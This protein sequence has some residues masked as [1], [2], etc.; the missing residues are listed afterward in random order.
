MA[1]D[2]QR[3]SVSPSHPTPLA[4]GLGIH[5]RSSLGASKA[6]DI[7]LN[8]SSPPQTPPP[9][10]PPPHHAPRPSSATGLSSGTN[11]GG[12]FDEHATLYDPGHGMAYEPSSSTRN[13]FPSSSPYAPSD[14]ESQRTSVTGAIQEKYHDYSAKHG[15][16]CTGSKHSRRCYKTW[17]GLTFVFLALFSTVFSGIFLVLA[18]YN[19]RY[20]STIGRKGR[21]T[22]SD[23]AT[24]T[25]VFAKA[26]ELSFTA[27]VVALIGQVLARRAYGKH[28]SKHPGVTL[29]EL[30]MRNW[31][32]QPGTMFTHWETVRYA[33]LS[34]LGVV[35]LLATVL[36]F[37]YT[38]AA[39]ALVQPQLKDLE[40][41]NRQLQG[42]VRTS[43]SNPE[44]FKRTCVAPLARLPQSD[45]HLEINCL[46]LRE[47]SN[48]YHNY[49]QW[50]TNWYDAASWGN[51]TRGSGARP[52]GTALFRENTT[53]TAPWIEQ[54]TTDPARWF[55]QTGWTVNNVTLA[56]PH[57]GVVSAARDPA[58]RI[59]Q[60]DELGDQAIYSIRAALPAT[61]V[62]VLCTTGLFRENLSM[63]VASDGV[64]DTTNGTGTALDDIFQWGPD[65]GENKWP[66]VFEKLPERYNSIVNA[67]TEY[68]TYG[69]DAIY[70]VAKAGES[71][72][73]LCQLRVGQTAQ[74]SM[75]YNAS[76][77][78]GTLEA[79]CEDPDDDLRYIKL[80]PDAPAGNVT[81][82]REWPNVGWEWAKAM[83]LND[84][85]VDANSAH[86][87]L[88]THLFPARDARGD[89]LHPDMP[90]P[91]EALAVMSGSTLLDATAD[92]PFV[93]FFNYT[94]PY[95]VL[96]APGRTQWFTARVHS[97]E[98]QS[99]G[100]QEYQR[101][102]FA[103]LVLVFVFNVGML[104]YFCLHRNWYLDFSDPMHLFALAINSPPS[105]KLA[106]VSCGGGAGEGAGAGRRWRDQFT[107]YWKM[108]SDGGHVFM[109]SPDLEGG[110]GR[111]SVARERWSAIGKRVESVTSPLLRMTEGTKRSK[112]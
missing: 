4:R 6:S 85:I 31:I 43:F 2:P 111:S 104:L 1:D 54:N 48:A 5:A 60:P 19:K 25:T 49:H 91:A 79:I 42:Q 58:N 98:Y 29:A 61:Y 37:L 67:T 94:A 34:V 76:G 53:V 72:Y 88:W 73:G 81:V 30:S 47:A 33:A 64:A 36:A 92:A 84:G 78:A 75:Q 80:V 65:W 7:N 8:L 74:C 96:A 102:F 57:V 97:Q 87:R 109:E 20:G 16:H 12:P 35:A 105:E 93:T 52:P 51:A 86:V 77:S 9:Q 89:P 112:A 55:R 95:Y 45:D 24:L 69:R 39:T 82:S 46:H 3:R 110:A 59:I 26:I 70:I 68:P 101:G 28:G 99:G 21:L 17:E 62:N 15:Q 11:S 100:T 56:M 83:A 23:A 38:S 10:S 27:L 66:P 106:E 22:P 13:L 14:K 107:Y 63:I 44:Y 103:V 32:V 41:V 40:A 108:G 50:L 71:N 90:S 18:A